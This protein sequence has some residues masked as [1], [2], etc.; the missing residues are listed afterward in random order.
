M[1]KDTI[2]D[3]LW[4]FAMKRTHRDGGAIT[5]SELATMAQCSEKSARDRLNTMAEKD[6]LRRDQNGRTV[7]YVPDWGDYEQTN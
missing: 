3:R 6:V 7:R 1:A 5:A 2:C 4:T